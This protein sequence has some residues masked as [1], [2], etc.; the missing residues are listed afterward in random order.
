[1]KDMLKTLFLAAGLSCLAGGTFAAT[2]SEADY[3]GDYSNDWQNVTTVT[4]T[5][6]ST[7]TGTWSYQNDYDYLAL[8][9]LAAGAQTITLT[10]SSIGDDAAA[11]SYSAGGDVYYKTTPYQWSGWEGTKLGTVG[12]DYYNPQD[13][14]LTLVLD[15]DFAGS[16]YLGLYGTYGRL[17]YNI[18][19]LN[20]ASADP[21]SGTTSPAP[22]PVPFSAVML[23]GGLG[24]LGLAA[25][26]R[27]TAA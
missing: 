15:D 20:W 24:A 22:V 3:G 13:D 21:A 16:L 6:S 17:N 11:Y 18:T 7:V 19:G 12:L 2:V 26:R 8:T 4:A 5:G 27:K 23:L 10:F 1:M 25:R 9:G 14:T